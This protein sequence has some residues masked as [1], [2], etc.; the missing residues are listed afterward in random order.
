VIKPLSP[1]Q[2][3]EMIARGEC[4]VVDVREPREWSRGHLPGARL[5]SFDR[6]RQS[7]KSALPRDNVLFVCAAGVRSQAAAQVA[8]ESGFSNVY[9][10]SGGTRSWV[11]AGLPLVKESA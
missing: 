4:D 3:Q 10:L 6:L 5:V 2:A 8:E 7:P 1:E 11:S 9:N